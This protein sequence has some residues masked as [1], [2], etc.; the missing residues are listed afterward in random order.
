MINEPG[1]CPSRLTSRPPE[2]LAARDGSL[3]S[4]C[5]LG[6]ETQSRKNVASTPFYLFSFPLAGPAAGAMSERRAASRPE[7]SFHTPDSRTTPP[8]ADHNN[9]DSTSQITMARRGERRSSRSC[10]AIRCSPPGG[11][12]RPRLMNARRGLRP[13]GCD[14]ADRRLRPPTSALAHLLNQ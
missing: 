12:R 2:C 7:S 10:E 3:G 4:F 1:P 5:K 9:A 6:P 8:I 13:A 11:R 14:G